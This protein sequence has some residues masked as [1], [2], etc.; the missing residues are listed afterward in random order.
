[1]NADGSDV[2][3]LIR[4]PLGE[5]I[6]EEDLGSAR[7][8]PAGSKIAFIRTPPGLPDEQHLYL[9]DADGSNDRALPMGEGTTYA[10]N[11]VWSPD[12]RRIA[13]QRWSTNGPQ[14]IGVL[15]L[16]TG[17]VIDAGPA[18]GDDGVV[19]VWSPD[20]TTILAVPADDPRFIAIDAT[21]GS[22]ETVGRGTSLERG[23]LNDFRPTWQRV[24][25]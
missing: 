5:A 16:A 20:G 23:V 11:L 9:M 13:F 24:M 17:E 8:S 14:P 18:P 2:R 7:W 21:D 15:T 22:S 19:F 4:I 1:M 6:G 12:G 25:P 10:N 3:P